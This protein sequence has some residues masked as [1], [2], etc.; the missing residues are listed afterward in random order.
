MRISS[1]SGISKIILMHAQILYLSDSL[2]LDFSLELLTIFSVIGNPS[3]GMS[4]KL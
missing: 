3:R 4:I 2:S 1:I